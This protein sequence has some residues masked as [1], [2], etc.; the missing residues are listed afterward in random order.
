MAVAYSTKKGVNK[1][2]EAF[3]HGLFRAFLSAGCHAQVFAYVKRSKNM[4]E[5]LIFARNK[6]FEQFFE[7]KYMSKKMS[8]LKGAISSFS[9]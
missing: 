9:R 4:S 5:N 8:N 2:D 1:Y 6:V 7:A 3:N